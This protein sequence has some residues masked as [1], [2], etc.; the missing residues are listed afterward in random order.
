MLGPPGSGKG[1]HAPVVVDLLGTPQLSTGDMLRAAVAEGTPVGVEAESVMK[2]GELVSDA[3]VIGIIEERIRAADCAKGFIL[4]GFPRTEAQARALDAL[5]SETGEAVSMVVAL[6]VDDALLE[7]RICGRWVHKESGR[8]YHAANKKPASLPAGAEP[9]VENMLDDETGE[10]LMQRKDDTKEALAT[11][12]EGYHAMTRP[13]LD[14]YA[15]VIKEVD[16]AKSME[17][18]KEQIH[19]VVA[20]FVK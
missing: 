19:T 16:A 7:E 13:L 15:P 9:T 12:L 1:T 20:P 11:R 18:I 14:Y 10:P 4:D 2:R 5:L 6:I 17:A 8:S 3:L